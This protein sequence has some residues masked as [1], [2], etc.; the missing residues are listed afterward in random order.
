MGPGGSHD[1]DVERWMAEEVECELA[2]TTYG[3]GQWKQHRWW[4]VSDCSCG[5]GGGCWELI[6]VTKTDGVGS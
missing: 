6:V 3:V 1:D 5:S 4:R 2:E